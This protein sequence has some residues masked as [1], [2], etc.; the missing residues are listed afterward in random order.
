VDLEQ[1]KPHLPMLASIVV[2][3]RAHRPV[4]TGVKPLSA[5]ELGLSRLHVKMS[6]LFLTNLK[7]SAQCCEDL[8]AN[9]DHLMVAQG[10]RALDRK[11]VESLVREVLLAEASRRGDPSHRRAT[12]RG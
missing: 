4:N 12:A 10:T 6:S 2:M 11:E 1:L 3:K 5:H 7:I 9:E 8:G